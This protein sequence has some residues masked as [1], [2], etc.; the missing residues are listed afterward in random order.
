MAAL[1]AS[2][3]AWAHVA[4]VCAGAA[5]MTSSVRA[6]RTSSPCIRRWKVIIVRL[7]L[8]HAARNGI[9]P[10]PS[11]RC[12]EALR[13][14]QVRQIIVD[15]APFFIIHIPT[16]TPWHLWAE[17]MAAGIGTCAHGGDTFL[18]FPAL[19]QTEV[20]S[21]RPKLTLHATRQIGPV[22]YAAILI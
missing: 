10:H 7:V 8:L 2:S 17:C 5:R 22:A 4:R 18:P 11:R 9:A 14:G 19:D 16:R 13:T 15:G 12:A 20:G 21:Y 3:A 6:L 1:R